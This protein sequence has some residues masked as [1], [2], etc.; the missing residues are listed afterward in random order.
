M[1]K[2]LSEFSEKIQEVG[3]KA[4]NTSISREQ[5]NGKDVAP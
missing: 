4:S 1:D 3:E 5:G 2:E